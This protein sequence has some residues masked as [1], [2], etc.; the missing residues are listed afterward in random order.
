MRSLRVLIAVVAGLA[1]GQASDVLASAFRVTPVQVVV[2]GRASTLLTLTNET[3]ESLRFQ[4]SVFEW[5]QGRGGEIELSPT[6]DIAFFPALLTLGPRQERKVRVASSVEAGDTEKTYRIFFEEL[7]PAESAERKQSEVRILTKMGIP[8]F[9][10]PSKP[11]ARPTLMVSQAAAGR[12]TFEV[13]NVGNTHFSIRGVA[14]TGRGPDGGQLFKTTTDGWYVLAGGTR[15]YD[16]ELPR[17]HCGELREL[18]VEAWTSA[19]DA[20][21]PSVVTKHNVT[22]GQ[23]C[24]SN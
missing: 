13:G 1:L 10:Q 18:T 14:V 7:P 4:I 12:L 3:D 19:D 5:T 11:A 17:D 2:S 9:V 8:I 16:V 22:A 20:K 23:A 21:T 15:V 6:T 24:K